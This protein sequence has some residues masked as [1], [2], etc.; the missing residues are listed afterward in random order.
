MRAKACLE[1]WVWVT[2]G[3]S[4][5]PEVY[6]MRARSDSFLQPGAEDGSAAHRLAYIFRSSPAHR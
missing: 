5:L 2:L 6:R 3:L 1:A 4:L